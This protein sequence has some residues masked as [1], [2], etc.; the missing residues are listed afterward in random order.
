MDELVA[1]RRSVPKRKRRD[2]CKHWGN[3]AAPCLFKSSPM[4]GFESVI[5]RAPRNFPG[6]NPLFSM[7]SFSRAHQLIENP[8]LNHPLGLAIDAGDLEVCGENTRKFSESLIEL[9][10]E[11]LPAP[12]Q[13]CRKFPLLNLDD[14]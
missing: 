10:D 5:C 1:V 14:F 2:V 8:C 11:R 6:A 13:F 12:I 4:H 7:K 3:S 9:L